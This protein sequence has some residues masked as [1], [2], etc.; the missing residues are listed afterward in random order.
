[1]LNVTDSQISPPGLLLLV[2]RYARNFCVLV[3]HPANLL[4][5]LIRSTSFLME[6]LGFSIY[7]VMVSANNDSFTSYFPLWITS[8]F[9]LLHWLCQ[10]LPQQ[11]WNIVMRVDILPTECSFRFSG[12]SKSFTDKQKLREFSTTKPDLQVLKELLKTGNTRERK[13]LQNQTTN[14]KVNSSRLIHIHNYLKCKWMKCS[15]QK[16]QTGWM[17]MKTRPIYIWSTRDPFQT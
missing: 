14:N 15:N 10:E 11:C 8:I 16:T 17:Y 12:E 5:S 13:Y 4:S 2:Y 6:S 9:A 3:L 1:M 7:R